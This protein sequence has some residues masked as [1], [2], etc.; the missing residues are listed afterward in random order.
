MKPDIDAWMNAYREAVQARFGERVRFLG[1]QGSQA[2]GEA[3]PNSDIDAALILD[4]VTAQDAAAYSELLDTLPYRDRSCGFLAG[5]E[6]LAAWEPSDF[7]QFYHDTVPYFGS[8]DALAARICREDVRRAVHTGACNIYHQC[9][10]NLVHGRRPGALAGLFKQA[11]FTLQAIAFLE[12]GRYERNK[13]ALAALL[14][15]ADRE[16]LRE[17]RALREREPIGWEEAV[18]LSSLLLAWTSSWIRACGGKACAVGEA[19]IPM[20]GE[21]AAR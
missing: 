19:P 21:E 2:R 17:G 3:G 18:R 1:L 9:M 13:E 11:V 15:P 8:L 12:S 10:H 7:F 5:W 14:S 6:E 16:I 4:R 20:Q